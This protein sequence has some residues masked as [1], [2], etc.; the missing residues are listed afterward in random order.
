MNSDWKSRYEVAQ[1]V[2]RSGGD[3]AKAIFDGEFDIEIK[4]D[5]SPVTIADKNAE[6]HIRQVI[7]SRFPG[8]GFLGEEYGDEPSTTGYRWI[9][10]P[11]DGTKSFV[12]K[13]PLWGTLL[14]LEYEGE[15][16]AGVAYIPTMNQLFH[17]L[18]GNGAY[19][20]S[21]KIAVSQVS[22]LAEAHMCYSSV[23]W[24]RE[25]GMEKQFLDLASSV[26]RSRGFGD[27]YG[28]L[29]VAQGSF[30]F[31]ID[32]GV[33]AWDIAALIPIVQEAGGQMTD[34][35]NGINILRPDTMA[36]NGLLHETVRK[37]LEKP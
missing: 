25:A 3:I 14:G 4:A 10:D 2:A 21:T 15:L 36:S 20:D 31:M 19:R 17:A 26:S 24:F 12:R 29:L 30:D 9:I 22:T 6:A 7:S 13:I 5:Q 8:D 35:S 18:R 27:F 16:I 32:T 33:H 11:I 34:W 1:E 23:S 37:Y 28:F